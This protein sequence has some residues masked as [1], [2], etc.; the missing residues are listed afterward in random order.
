[1]KGVRSSQSGNWL[2]QGI[3]LISHEPWLE[4]VRL[5]ST[6]KTLSQE[7]KRVL[8]WMKK[9]VIFLCTRFSLHQP[10]S[11]NHASV[12]QEL[13]Q[14][15]F[16]FH[17]SMGPDWLETIIKLSDKWAAWPGEWPAH[18]WRDEE[19]DV[20]DEEKEEE[21]RVGEGKVG[22]GQ[23]GQCGQSPPLCTYWPESLMIPVQLWSLEVDRIPPR[24]WGL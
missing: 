1:M 22:E 11:W 2:L 12:L 4:N 3:G 24:P 8:Q 17:H 10:V 7:F 20:G 16:W 18:R 13:C 6:T 21:D 15:W 5:N 23:W 19:A 9:C 14:S